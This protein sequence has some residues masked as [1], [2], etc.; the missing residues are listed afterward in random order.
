MADGD[1][2]KEANLKDGDHKEANMEDGDQE[3]QRRRLCG[4]FLLVE[5]CSKECQ[6]NAWPLHKNVCRPAA[7]RQRPRY[8]GDCQ[9]TAPASE[10]AA[11]AAAAAAG[12][13]AAAAGAAAAAPATPAKVFE[14]ILKKRTRPDLV[15]VVVVEGDGGVEVKISGKSYMTPLDIV[16]VI[17]EFG[18]RSLIGIPNLRMYITN[19]TIKSVPEGSHISSNLSGLRLYIK[20]CTIKGD[21]LGYLSSDFHT[22]SIKNSHTTVSPEF[23]KRLRGIRILE[24][25]GCRFVNEDGSQDLGPGVANGMFECLKGGIEELDM[26]GCFLPGL[27]NEGLGHLA[28]VKKINLSNVWFTCDA[29]RYPGFTCDA[30]HYLEG[31]EFI[32]VSGLTFFMTDEIIQFLKKTLIGLN[33]GGCGGITDKAFEGTQ[34]EYLNL[35]DGYCTDAVMQH[36]QTVKELSI[37]GC[38]N[39]TNGA[40]QNLPPGLC[41]LNI[42]YNDK[43]SDASVNPDLKRESSPMVSSRTFKREGYERKYIDRV[44]VW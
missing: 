30:L 15:D 11:G 32:D 14:E 8:N 33:L 36:I 19:C 43:L 4:K 2:H 5:Y 39:L 37:M 34:L 9:L 27:T 16:A 41:Y 12:A 6:R 22:L 17:W 24:L 1:D 29:S 23:F 38:S 21:M 40:V 3:P 35:S 13:A 10:A 42:T 31:V 20:R 25:P 44:R 26:S 28:G 7:A 18:L